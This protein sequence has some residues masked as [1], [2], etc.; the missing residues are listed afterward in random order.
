MQGLANNLTSAHN[1]ALRNMTVAFN[2]TMPG[3]NV[4]YYNTQAFLTGVVANATAVRLQSPV[5]C[6]EKD[7]MQA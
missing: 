7:S 5:C 2:A 1:A 6:I 4:H 3:A